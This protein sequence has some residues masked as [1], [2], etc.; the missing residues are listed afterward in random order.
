MQCVI[1]YGTA[2]L[3]GGKWVF[4]VRGS[5]QGKGP[6]SRSFTA[7]LDGTQSHL[8]HLPT[9]YNSEAQLHWV[10]DCSDC[11]AERLPSGVQ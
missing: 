5:S 2:L 11:E 9:A 4:G 6:D 7:S 10:L 1:W 3:L 8:R